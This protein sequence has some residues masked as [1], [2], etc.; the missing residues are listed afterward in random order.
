M[1]IPLLILAYRAETGL[2]HQ[3]ILMSLFIPINLI[4]E[5]CPKLFHIHR[6]VLL[7][8]NVRLHGGPVPLSHHAQTLFR[9]GNQI[10]FKR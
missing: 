10:K 8:E 9:A 1:T 7:R 2:V 3:H 5:V 6:A 4:P